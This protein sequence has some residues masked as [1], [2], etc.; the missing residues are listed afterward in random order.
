MLNRIPRVTADSGAYYFLTPGASDRYMSIANCSGLTIDLQGS[1]VYMAASYLIWLSVTDC[2]QVTLTG[3][4]LDSL[5]LPFTQ[6]QITGVA[7]PVLKIFYSNLPGWPDPTVFN[8]ITNPDGSAQQLEALV[9]RNGKLVPGTNL[10]P[11]SAPIQQGMLRI[12]PATSPWTQPGVVATYQPGDTLVFMARG[13][14]APILIQGGDGNA[15]RYIDVYSSGAIAV[16]LDNTSGAQVQNV[17]V[18]PRPST[19]RLISSNADGIH[20]SYVHANNRVYRCFVSHTVDDGIAINSPFLGFVDSQISPAELVANR[21]FS[22]V[23]PNGLP[24]QFVN[25]QTAQTLSAANIE[26]QE[27]PYS[28]PPDGNTVTVTLNQNAGTLQSG[29]GF[30]NGPAQNRGAGSVI[31]FNTI[32]DV[33]SARGIYMGGVQGVT[34][35]DNIIRRTDCGGI[36][37]HEDLSSY[38]V[39]PAQDIQI[40]NNMVQDAIGPAAV[41]TG[42]V[43]AIASIFVISTNQNFG[44]VSATPNTNIT[45]ANNSILDS[46]RGAIWISNLDGG[47]VEGNHICRYSLYPNLASW[48]LDAGAMSE[49]AGDFRQGIVVRSSSGVVVQSNDV[50]QKSLRCVTPRQLPAGE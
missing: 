45:V 43:A 26:S 48:G 13:S 16:H 6:V 2:N 34:I 25:T 1:D 50:E 10:L 38:P 28:D 37:A 17:R 5:Q 47:L 8:S 3:F 27:P 36:V 42:T 9:F 44:F 18:M 35:R 12:T 23:F 19:D 29:F 22:S 33:L 7:A 40:L 15:L 24:V 39:G 4:T 20:L 41:G 49:L 14:Q 31:E 30:I 46:G 21:N 11:I 32:E